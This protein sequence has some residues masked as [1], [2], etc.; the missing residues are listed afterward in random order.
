MSQI[1]STE[2]RNLET[3]RSIKQDECLASVSIHFNGKYAE[4]NFE[5]GQSVY[6]F[7]G[8]MFLPIKLF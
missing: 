5:A 3:L 4:R 1:L 8:K 7:G 6:Q 2:K